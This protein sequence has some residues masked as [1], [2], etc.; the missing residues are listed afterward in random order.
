MIQCKRC[1]KC[2]Y[3]IIDG[4][5]HK[6]KYLVRLSKNITACR[7]YEHRLGTEIF[8]NKRGFSLTCRLREDDKRI[9]EG[10]PLNL[11]EKVSK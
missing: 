5:K 4:K 3:F 6:C 7:I 9:I 11:L 10:C 2:C 1:G 8:K